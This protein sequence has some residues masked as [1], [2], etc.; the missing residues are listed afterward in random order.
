MNC[1]EN[2]HNGVAVRA[3]PGLRPTVLLKSRCCCPLVRIDMLQTA[4]AIVKE[5]LCLSFPPHPS[6]YMRKQWRLLPA[7]MVTGADV[8]GASPV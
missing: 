2:T 7:A 6:L 1:C 4:I 5:S 3:C 8:E